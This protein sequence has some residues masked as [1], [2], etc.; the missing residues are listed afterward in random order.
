LTPREAM[1]YAVVSMF[2]GHHHARHSH[3]GHGPVE[4]A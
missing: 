1:G 4:A 2:T 3:S